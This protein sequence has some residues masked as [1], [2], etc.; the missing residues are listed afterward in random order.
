MDRWQIDFYQLSDG[1][2]PALT[3]FRKQEA[4]VQA[5][6]AR[7]FELLQANG[8]FIGMPH[9]RLIKNSKLFEIRVEQNTNIYRIFYF[10]HTGQ[11]FIL[12]HGFQKKTQKTPM[13]EIEI[14]EVRM[15]AFLAEED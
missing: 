3:W 2:S 11:R 1:S 6:F 13:K 8:T 15:K 12:L 14:A 4:K 9:V 10:A 7:I 5:K